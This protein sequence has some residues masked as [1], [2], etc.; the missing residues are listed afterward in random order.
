MPDLDDA[1]GRKYSWA[2]APRY[3][4]KPAETGPLA[5]LLVAGSP[6]FV[7]LNHAKGAGVF[8][9]EF[10]R[11]VRPSFLLPAIEQWLGEMGDCS[12][13]F[14][15]DYPMSDTTKGYG[16]VLA[17]RGILG[18]WVK[19]V[20]G[21]IANYQVITPTAWNASP[22]DAKGAHGPCEQAIIGTH[23]K[24]PVDPVEVEQIVRSFDPCLVCTV[25]AVDLR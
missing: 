12:S 10:A 5:D 20:D 2:K 13:P 19:I 9:R 6:L 14:F 3:N 16:L 11:M 24:N 7:E 23:V 4:G 21:K 15:Q 22:M 18:H 25:H 1:G 17:S 8:L